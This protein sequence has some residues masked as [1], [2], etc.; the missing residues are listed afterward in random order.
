[1]PPDSNAMKAVIAASVA[2]Q[3]S[4]SDHIERPTTPPLRLN[5]LSSTNTTPVSTREA[6]GSLPSPPPTIRKPPPE[7]HSLPELANQYIPETSTAEQVE[8]S[9]P[10]KFCVKP[11]FWRRWSSGMY[12]SFASD[13]RRQFDPVPFAREH[14]IPVNEVQQVF[15]TVVCNPLYD[16]K[17]ARRRGEEGLQELFDLF[18]KYATPSRWWSKDESE[19]VRGELADIEEGVVIVTARKTGAKVN[20]LAEHLSVADVKYLKA[21]VDAHE[22]ETLNLGVTKTPSHRKYATPSRLWGGVGGKKKVKGELAGIQE[23]VV[24]VTGRESGTEYTIP[25]EQLTKA[26][27]KYLSATVDAHELEMLDLD[28]AKTPSDV[29][30]LD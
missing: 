28:V 13:L 5:T 27:V 1:M 16:A 10:Q 30:M 20:I 18:N 14:G 7:L 12:A 17:E 4:R 11:A 22:M 19:M 24:V 6:T 25:T 3:I 29:A 9:N 21:T 26:D 2:K 8:Y 15:S 23:G